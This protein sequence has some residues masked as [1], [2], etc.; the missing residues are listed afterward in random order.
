MRFLRWIAEKAKSALIWTAISAGVCGLLGILVSNSAI[1]GIVGMVIN[2]VLIDSV[3]GGRI[4]ATQKHAEAYA[5]QNDKFFNADF[6]SVF[7]HDSLQTRLKLLWVFVMPALSLTTP[8]CNM[9]SKFFHDELGLP[10][11]I[12]I[13]LLMVFVG[14]MLWAAF[15]SINNYQKQVSKLIAA[16]RA[17]IKCL[18]N[19]NDTPYDAQLF[20]GEYIDRDKAEELGL[21]DECAI[22]NEMHPLFDSVPSASQVSDRAKKAAQ[23]KIEAKPQGVRL[24]QPK[25]EHLA[26]TQHQSGMQQ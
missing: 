5:E 12:I 23:K 21:E 7:Y 10:W 19:I 25:K 6:F 13:A 15:L 4:N 1:P 14:E 22:I 3:M 2:T 16:R 26:E 9:L 17:N 18:K 24:E 8:L 11:K 20:W